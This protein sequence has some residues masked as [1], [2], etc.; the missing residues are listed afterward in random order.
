MDVISSVLDLA[1]RFVEA[2]K[3]KGSG[4][5]LSRD[6]VSGGTSDEEDSGRE[7]ASRWAHTPL[8]IRCWILDVGYWMLDVGGSTGPQRFADLPGRVLL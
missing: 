4:M 6:L 1:F 2:F 7:G 5:D 8:D 3:M